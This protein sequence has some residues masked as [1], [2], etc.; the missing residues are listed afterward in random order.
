MSEDIA[1]KYFEGQIAKDFFHLICGD[2]IGSGV[3]RTVFASKLNP[4]H[5]IKFEHGATGFCNAKEYTLWNELEHMP[6]NV[7]KWFAPVLF[8]S[9]CGNILIQQR[10]SPGPKISYPDKI[11]KHFTDTKYANFGFLGNQLACH[12]YGNF[13]IT[14]GLNNRLI[15]AD[16]WE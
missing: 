2:E 3:H 8:I 1:Y 11:P 16:W 13:I 9:P 10:T 15:K 12:D 14:N 7:K 5:V 6:D 4:N